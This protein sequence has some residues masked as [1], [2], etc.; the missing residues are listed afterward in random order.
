MACEPKRGP[1]PVYWQVGNEPGSGYTGAVTNCF[2][3]TVPRNGVD[4][5]DVSGTSVSMC[6]C[7]YNLPHI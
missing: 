4:A 3:F 1:I 2:S 7:F 6:F 5:N